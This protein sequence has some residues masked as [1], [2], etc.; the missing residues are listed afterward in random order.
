MFVPSIALITAFATSDAAILDAT[1]ARWETAAREM[2]SLHIEYTRT[3]STIGEQER[4]QSITL[5]GLRTADGLMADLLGRLADGREER[6][7]YRD[8]AVYWV[9]ATGKKAIRFQ[10]TDALQRMADW[11]LSAVVMLDRARSEQIYSVSIHR[12]DEWFYWVALTPK[13]APTGGPT[14]MVAVLH[15]KNQTLP[16]GTPRSA[17]TRDSA[18][19]TRWDIT[20]WEVNGETSPKAEV[21]ALPAEKDGWTITEWTWPPKW[22]T[23]RK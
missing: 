1:F 19:T 18:G 2:K 15:R 13:D 22:N 6:Y 20:K 17:F 4:E 3:E 12:R 5:R 10:T 7:L 21:F 14:A 8:G 23:N 11:H 16:V 9:D